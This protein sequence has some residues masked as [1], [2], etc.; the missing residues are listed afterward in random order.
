MEAVDPMVFLGNSGTFLDTDRRMLCR[1][2]FPPY[3][4]C[5]YRILLQSLPLRSVLQL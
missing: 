1:S 2:A 4:S 3:Q 5:S